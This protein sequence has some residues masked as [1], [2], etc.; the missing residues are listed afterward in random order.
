[1]PN[2][3][4]TLGNNEWLLTGDSLW[5]ENGVYE[6]RMQD[7]GK[8]VVYENGIAIWQNTSEQRD[9]VKGVL[10]EEDGNLVV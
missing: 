9:D 3:H 4:S 7:D 2:T 6:C 1:M 10:M 8:I 5:S